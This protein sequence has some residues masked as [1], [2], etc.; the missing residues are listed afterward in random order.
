MLTLTSS[1]DCSHQQSSI[2]TSLSLHH[3]FT[4][5]FISLAHLFWGEDSVLVAVPHLDEAPAIGALQDSEW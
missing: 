1:F 3:L 2:S 4:C 5:P